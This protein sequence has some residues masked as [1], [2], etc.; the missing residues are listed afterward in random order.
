MGSD[1]D[2]WLSCLQWVISRQVR[3]DPATDKAAGPVMVW[4]VVGATSGPLRPQRPG[5]VPVSRVR[6]ASASPLHHGT[7]AGRAR[8]TISPSQ[9]LTQPDHD[10][11][12]GIRVKF[13][14][15]VNLKLGTG[16]AQWHRDRD[17]P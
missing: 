12:T 7:R 2:V 8:V 6:P 14:L 17:S 13:Q 16:R 4:W 3:W 15:Q 11:A 9:V 10:S 1:S 5:R